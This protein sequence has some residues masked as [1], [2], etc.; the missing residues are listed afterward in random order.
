MKLEVSE[1]D[2]RERAGDG[3]ETVGNDVVDPNHPLQP[4]RRVGE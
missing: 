4:S 1:G 2:L 3:F